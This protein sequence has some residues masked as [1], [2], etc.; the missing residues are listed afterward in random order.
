MDHC[1][2]CKDSR[3]RGQYRSVPAQTNSNNSG[4]SLRTSARFMKATDNYKI[5]I[6]LK[7]LISPQQLPKLRQG[8]CSGTVGKT[9]KLEF[10]VI[11]KQTVY[12]SNL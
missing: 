7:L 9:Q 11:E 3:Q 10:K 1:G 12:P 4:S 8:S 5:F 2:Q 6:C